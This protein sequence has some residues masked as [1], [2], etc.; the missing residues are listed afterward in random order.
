MTEFNCRIR[1]M[2][3]GC[4]KPNGWFGCIAVPDG[5]GSV[6]LTGVSTIPLTE[7]MTIKVQA[8]LVSANEYKAI[9]IDV[10]MNTPEEITAFLRS[11]P[12]ISGSMATK[13]AY[14]VGA[15]CIDIINNG[16]AETKNMSDKFGLDLSDKQIQNLIE[17][18]GAF[19]KKQTLIK[20]LP[21]IKSQITIDKILTFFADNDAAEMKTIIQ[22]NPFRLCEIAN[23]PFRTADTIAIR[24]GMQPL[25]PIR[26]A[27][28]V[29]DIIKSGIGGLF[30]DLSVNEELARLKMKTELLLGIHFKDFTDFGAMIV[31]AEQDDCDKITIEHYKQD[32]YHL[33]RTITYNAVMSAAAALQLRGMTFSCLEDIVTKDLK[34]KGSVMPGAIKTK[35]QKY[36]SQYAN[37]ILSRYERNCISGSFYL[38]D[39]QRSAIINSLMNKTSIITGGPGY[40]KT[41]VIECI[42]GCW[43]EIFGAR[44][45]TILAP[46]GKAAAKIRTMVDN[47]YKVMTVSAALLHYK[48]MGTDY[49]K[50]NTQKNELVILDESSMLN[51]EEAAML[52][53]TLE[54][55]QLCFVG[56]VD[57]L[58]PI[59]PGRF[60]SDIIEA[61]PSYISINRLTKPLRNSGLIRSNIEKINNKDKDLD[62]DLN[63]MPFIVLTEEN[64][65]AVNAIT[66]QYS[67]ELYELAD[68]SR[69]ALLCPVRKGLI[70]TDNLNMRLQSIMCAENKDALP[71]YDSRRRKN[72]F[73]TKGYPIPDTFF[74]TKEAYTRLRIG[75]IV[76]NTKN[77]PNIEC[78]MYKNDDCWNGKPISQSLGISNGDTGRIIAYEPPLDTKSN[79]PELAHQYMLVQFFDGRFARL[80]MTSGEAENIQL[81]YAMTVHKAQGS[82]YDTVIYV[83]PHRLL[84]FGDNGFLSKNLVYTAVSRAKERVVLMGSKDSLGLCIEKDLLPEKSNFKERL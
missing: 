18:V 61:A 50:K 45:I 17:G 43:A 33:Y 82:E 7:G 24:L 58:P 6:K 29:D 67:D 48:H 76:L 74:G 31:R 55:S 59:E 35:L 12:G 32:H 64:E 8:D 42:A 53:D 62:Y 79:D 80:D 30:V 14:R 56:D 23:I 20:F 37:A 9:S 4:P 10:I 69:I 1:K 27:Y 38:T 77:M 16:F 28:A 2:F 11:I 65:D 72:I 47:K 54:N 5:M 34:K 41:T 83:S 44:S 71:T 39:E 22:N 15:S 13:I 36:M 52:L 73:I 63:R 46:T 60:F 66:E 19:T 25:A 81:G 68:V 21:E 78:S 57:Q 75:D 3:K 84:S 70:G 51:I 40:G 49:V 26:I